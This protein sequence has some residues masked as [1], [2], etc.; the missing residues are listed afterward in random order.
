M[1]ISIISYTIKTIIRYP[2]NNNNTKKVLICSE[3]FCR[4]KI[5]CC[6]VSEMLPK[7]DRDRG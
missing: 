1:P 5:K 7:E 2:N 3:K 4:D 6:T